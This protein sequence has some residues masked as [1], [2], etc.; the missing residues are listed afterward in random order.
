MRMTEDA[1]VWLSFLEERSSVLRQLPAFVQNIANSDAAA[2]QFDHDLGRKSAL[3]IIIDVAG[4]CRY[5]SDGSKLLDDG[6]P[7][8]IAGTK[9]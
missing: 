7:A 2:C 4:N 8:D 9:R 6:E 3:Y 5:G 1:E